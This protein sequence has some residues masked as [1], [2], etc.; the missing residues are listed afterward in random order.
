MVNQLLG[1]LVYGI[2]LLSISVLTVSRFPFLGDGL[3]NTSERNSMDNRYRNLRILL[4]I[5]IT[6]LTVISIYYLMGLHLFLVGSIII[7][8]ILKSTALIVWY[9][10]IIR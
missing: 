6:T 3:L 4:V 10:K 8:G 1:F 5:S 2:G 7:I 9:G